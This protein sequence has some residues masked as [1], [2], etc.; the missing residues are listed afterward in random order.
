MTTDL[1]LEILVGRAL[2][3]RVPAD[4]VPP[5]RFCIQQRERKVTVKQ[6]AVAFGIPRRSL[7]EQLHRAGLPPARR[8]I[9]W[10]RLL[11]AAWDI[12]HTTTSVERIALDH[13]FHPVSRL[14][15]LL[16]QW[17][18][19][20]PSALRKGDSFGWVLRCFERDLALSTRIRDRGGRA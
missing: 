8:P 4:L 6:V 9:V 1:E 15:S 19:T 20:T 16:K 2:Q 5:G 12:C 17:A 11:A 10:G 3:R 14:R 13:G 7:A 18:H